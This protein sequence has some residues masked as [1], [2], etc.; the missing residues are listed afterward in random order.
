MRNDIYLPS[1]KAFRDLQWTLIH[2]NIISNPPSLDDTH[3]FCKKHAR[4][5]YYD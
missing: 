4:I 2:F 5:F 1:K 3:E